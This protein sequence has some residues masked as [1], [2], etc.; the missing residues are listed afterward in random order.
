MVDVHEAAICPRTIMSDV[1]QTL[2]SRFS[3]W[4]RDKA[5]CLAKMVYILQNIYA[6]PS[7]CEAATDP[8]LIRFIRCL[9]IPTVESLGSWALI[10][11][12]S[13]EVALAS[14]VMFVLIFQHVAAA[15]CNRRIFRLGSCF[16][17]LSSN[18]L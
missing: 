8:P 13:L 3:G 12:N 5:R 15:A 1:L 18:F 11:L 2:P 14:I 10:S 6:T 7:S 17:C 16:P 9:A 4:T